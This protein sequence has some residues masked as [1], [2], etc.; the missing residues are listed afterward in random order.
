MEMNFDSSITSGPR[1]VPLSGGLLGSGP[2]PPSLLQRGKSFTS[3]DLFESN[4]TSAAGPDHRGELKSYS[5]LSGVRGSGSSMSTITNSPPSS[6]DSHAINREPEME[7]EVEPYTP[8]EQ[9]FRQ[10]LQDQL[11]RQ[12]SSATP[13]ARK[14]RSVSP[15]G[16]DTTR[17]GETPRNTS[18]SHEVPWT[19]PV[20]GRSD[21][22]A[23]SSNR[24]CN[25][26]PLFSEDDRHL[27]RQRTRSNPRALNEKASTDLS[28]Q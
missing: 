5:M 16:S 6:D 11:A 23:S 21:L 12:E 22:S 4:S 27:K 3:D 15:S 19:A 28:E 13:T 9:T 7:V 14:G 20:P 25:E 8:T 2:R 1:R 18:P 24:R 10:D 17:V 26:A